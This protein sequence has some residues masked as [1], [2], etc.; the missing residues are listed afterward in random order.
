MGKLSKCKGINLLNYISQK[1]IDFEI[2]QYKYLS[3]RDLEI[4]RSRGNIIEEENVNLLENPEYYTTIKFMEDGFKLNYVHREQ[5]RF[6]NL[7]LW[8]TKFVFDGKTVYSLDCSKKTSLENAINMM[9][10]HIRDSL[11][12]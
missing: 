4:E 12:L 9:D 5:K 1:N 7:P 8:R 10:G 3:A 6:S 2:E 11:N